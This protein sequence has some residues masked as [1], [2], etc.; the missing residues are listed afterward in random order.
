MSFTM[1]LVHSGLKKRENGAMDQKPRKK[2]KWVTI[3]DSDIENIAT[4]WNKVLHN[5]G[6]CYKL[7]ETF[8]NY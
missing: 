8:H 3:Y 5:D 7:I 2:K 1:V 4:I 6:I